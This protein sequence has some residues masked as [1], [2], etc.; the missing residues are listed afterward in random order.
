MQLR[1]KNTALT[2]IIIGWL[3]IIGGITG[4]GLMAYLMYNAG[5]LNGALLLLLL[6]GLSLFIFSIYSG[7]KLLTCQDKRPGIIFSMINQLLQVFQVSMF[8]FAFCYS[9]GIE[10][11]TG[12]QGM[13]IKFNVAVVTSNF[14]MIIRSTTEGY[15]KI[16]IIPVIVL[17]TLYS[18]WLELNKKNKINIDTTMDKNFH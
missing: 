4:L 1:I 11:A 16:N 18:I 3:Q 14:Q 5:S 2:I 6:I 17:L 15:F 12:F 8:G 9:S 10:L 7:K 13:D